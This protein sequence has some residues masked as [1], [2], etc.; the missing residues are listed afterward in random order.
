MYIATEGPLDAKIM[1]VGEA[2]GTE[3][4]KIGRPFQ[5]YSGG[6]LDNLLAQAGIARH[7]CLIANVAR[8]RPPAGRISYYFEDKQCTIPKPK[9]TA[10]ID[11]LKEEIELKYR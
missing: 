10:W 1:L 6:V 8:E 4:D 3:E 5:G 9:L 7:Q 11:K 2:P